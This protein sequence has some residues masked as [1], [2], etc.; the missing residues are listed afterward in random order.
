MHKV[1]RPQSTTDPAEIVQSFKVIYVA[2]LVILFEVYSFFFS[3]IKDRKYLTVKQPK[4]KK[5]LL[6]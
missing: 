3:V 6:I 5:K 2:T 4:K 1:Y